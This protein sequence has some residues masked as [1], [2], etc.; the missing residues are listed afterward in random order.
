MA[1]SPTLNPGVEQGLPQSV[2]QE[3]IY[4]A[5]YIGFFLLVLYAVVIIMCLIISCKLFWFFLNENLAYVLTEITSSGLFSQTLG[6][7]TS[8]FTG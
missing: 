4:K 8:V 7:H 1:P 6:H 5:I 3:N 2:L